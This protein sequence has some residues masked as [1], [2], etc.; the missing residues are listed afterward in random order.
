MAILALLVLAGLA[1][2]APSRP[3]AVA[4][5]DASGGAVHWAAFAR[6]ANLDA[7]LWRFARHARG[8]ER[9]LPSLRY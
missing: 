2:A 8:L 7:Q 4:T 6:T 9:A 1:L 5:V 3:G